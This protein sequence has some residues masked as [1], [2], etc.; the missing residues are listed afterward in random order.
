MIRKLTLDDA[1]FVS[2]HMRE[3]DRLEVMATRWNDAAEQFAMDVYTCG[4]PAYTV[5][6]LGR[7][8][9]VLGCTFTQPGVG[10]AWMVGTEDMPR[11]AIEA[12]R[13]AR[14]ALASLLANNVHRI[15]AFSAG[16][17]VEAHAWL[18]VLGFEIESRLERWGRNGEDFFMFAMVRD[19]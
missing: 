17:H 12:T 18:R 10:T 9:V 16:F 15:H 13:F 7:P 11:V 4:G 1:L 5:T 19:R 6:R 8:V 14:K 3:V 2:R